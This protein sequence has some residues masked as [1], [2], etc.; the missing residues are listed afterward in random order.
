MEYRIEGSDLQFVR[1]TLAPGESAV[2]EPGAMMYI[3]EG[4]DMDT[5]LGDG[6]DEGLFSRLAGAFKRKLTG[7]NIF[8]TVFTNNMTRPLNVAFAAPSPGKIM[9]VDLAGMGGSLICQKRAFMAGAQGVRVGLA[10]KKR[11]RVGF[12]GGEGFILQRLTG[13]GTAFIHA[14]GTMTQIDLAPGQALRVDT[15]C[16]AA[17]TPSATYDI[18]YV[19]KIKTSLFGGEGLFLAHLKGPGTVWLQSLPLPRL[20]KELAVG[21]RPRGVGARLLYLGLII[22]S[23]LI[24]LFAEAPSP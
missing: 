4:I 13:R 22:V 5:R 9:A 6:I 10:F 14:S 23:V 16:L 20:V 24:A 8:S 17:L 12:F 1:V 3:D 11:L 19:G 21:S 2:G 18:K 15:G 7:E